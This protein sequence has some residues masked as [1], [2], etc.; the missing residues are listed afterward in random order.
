MVFEC[1]RCFIILRNKQRVI[2]QSSS[3]VERNEGRD[4]SEC[5]YTNANKNVRDNVRGKKNEKKK[6]LKDFAL[7]KYNPNEHTILRIRESW[8]FNKTKTKKSKK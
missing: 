5:S 4:T 2:F 7:I 3:I 1:K 8:E 6:P